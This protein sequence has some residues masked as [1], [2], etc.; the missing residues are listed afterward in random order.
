[1]DTLQV[2]SLKNIFNPLKCE[3]KTVLILKGEFLLYREYGLD[4]KP[5]R[6]EQLLNNSGF[7]SKSLE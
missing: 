1:M 6:K 7:G 3:D 5:R 2:A 4:L